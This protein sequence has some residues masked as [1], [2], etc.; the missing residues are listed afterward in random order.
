MGG[1]EADVCKNDEDFHIDN[2]RL[3]PEVNISTSFL[4]AIEAFFYGLLLGSVWFDLWFL[5][6]SRGLFW[7]G[8]SRYFAKGHSRIWYVFD[9]CIVFLLFC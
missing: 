7:L 6:G 2:R 3:P 9:A 8:S 5:I 4:N 1:R